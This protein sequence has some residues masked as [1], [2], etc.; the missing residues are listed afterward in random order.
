M[1]AAK[2]AKV[3]DGFEHHCKMCDF[4]RP[5]AD[6]LL[7]HMRMEHNSFNCSFCSYV[8]GKAGDLEVHMTAVHHSLLCIYCGVDGGNLRAL[9]RH[10]SLDHG[11]KPRHCKR[12]NFTTPNQTVLTNHVNT[13]HLGRRPRACPCCDYVAYTDAAVRQHVLAIHK[14]QKPF[15]CLK[16]PMSFARKYQVKEH[17][18]RKH[19]VDLA[20]TMSEESLE[21]SYKFIDDEISESQ[22]QK[23]QS[24]S[25]D[26]KC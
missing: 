18:K 21:L 1:I 10:Y 4:S 7:Y 16:C 23:W 19:N 26:C 15:F 24:D 8:G 6:S 13:V 20:P 2:R 22:D 3:G 25:A 9:R 12:C 5:T 17:L 14:K 11:T